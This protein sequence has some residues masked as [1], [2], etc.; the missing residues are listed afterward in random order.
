MPALRLGWISTRKRL[1]LAGL[2]LLAIFSGCKADSGLIDSINA[3]AGPYAFSLLRWELDTLSQ[4]AEAYIRLSDQD[5]TDSSIVVAYFEMVG[6]E[7]DLR[8]QID[9]VHGGFIQGDIEVLQAALNAISADRAAIEQGVERVLA[10]QL[11]L[12]AADLGIYNPLDPYWD[13]RL[14]FPPVK[15]RL[16]EPP[17]LLVVSP[18]EYI[19]RFT[20]VTLIP[21]ISQTEAVALEDAIEGLGVS[22]IVV[23]LGG[24]ATYPSFVNNNYGLR[25]ALDTAA[26]EWVHQ[27]LFFRP[28]GFRYALYELGIPQP[29]DIV[30]MNETLAGMVAAELAT[31]A[32]TRFYSP[33]MSIQAT[34][35]AQPVFNFYEELCN[36]RSVVDALLESGKV[37]EA[38]DYMDSRRQEFA[39]HGYYLRKLNQAYFAFYGCYANQPGFENPIG[40]D[41][42]TL[43]D[44]SISLSDFVQVASS[45]TSRDDL[46]RAVN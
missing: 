1:F 14:T 3:I 45:F 40:V 20:E 29:L 11:S 15:L 34:Q 38:E 16:Q 13:I 35:L 12:V 6:R 30:I 41:M 19:D 4:E 7:N 31:E 23:G 24:M 33:I 46:A 27:Y 21:D 37:T 8:W 17:K 22:A 10:R 39:E 42:Q 2:S 18:R 9:G 36:T 26:E 43:K 28:L 5:P 44:R 25:A 32:Y